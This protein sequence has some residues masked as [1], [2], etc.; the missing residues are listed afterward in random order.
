MDLPAPVPIACGGVCYI[1]TLNW[2]A[3]VQVENK[4]RPYSTCDPGWWPTSSLSMKHEVTNFEPDLRCRGAHR[5]GVQFCS[6]L[7]EIFRLAG[8]RPF[9]PFVVGMI[10]PRP[11]LTGLFHV[12]ARTSRT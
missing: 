10:T 3:H 4:L 12:W 11:L 9:S 5:P 1:P 8:S 6:A 2:F 7:I